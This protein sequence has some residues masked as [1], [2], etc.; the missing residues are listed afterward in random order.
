[1]AT[2]ANAGTY[3]C[4]HASSH[5]DSLRL[6]VDKSEIPLLTHLLKL[7]NFLVLVEPEH[8]EKMQKDFPPRPLMVSRS[9]TP[10]TRTKFLSLYIVLL[11]VAI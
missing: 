1:M 7:K 5:A 3:T 10:A 11:A 6:F 9:S 4:K 2:S 8:I